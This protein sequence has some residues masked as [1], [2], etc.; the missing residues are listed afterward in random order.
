MAGKRKQSS[1]AFPFQVVLESLQRDTT[2]EEVCRKFGVSSSMVSRWR[3]AFVQPGAEVFSDQRSPANR[4][5]AAGYEPGEEP[6]DLKKLIGDLTVHNELFK[7][8]ERHCWANEQPAESGAGACA[9]CFHQ[10]D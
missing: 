5:K 7:K 1:N 9:V 2:I 3:Q 4:A 8:S 10:S 6:E